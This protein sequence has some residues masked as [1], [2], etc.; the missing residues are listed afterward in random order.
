MGGCTMKARPILFSAPMVR[1]LLAGAKTQTR[2]VVKPLT[3][4]HPVVNLAEW[5]MDVGTRDYTG[6]FDDPAS[7]GFVGAEDGA[8]MAL[9]D[10]PELCPY[11]RPGD[12]LWV[13]E[14]FCIGNY[15]VGDA[16]PNYTGSQ[17]YAADFVGEPAMKWK[18]SI[19]MPRAY[20]RLTL[21]ITDVRVERLQDISEEDA[22]AEGAEPSIVGADLEHLRFRAGFQTLWESINGAGSW[23]ANPWV[24]AIS[25]E[26]IH[27][28]VDEVLSTKEPA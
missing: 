9:A 1:A 19:H 3:K 17:P 15:A 11:G 4:N 21:R 8:D 7:W 12:L 16:G 6:K 2:R 20:S 23:A 10:W 27:A 26:V 18:P 22:R 13:R 5:G 14:T 25:F 28:N 24:W